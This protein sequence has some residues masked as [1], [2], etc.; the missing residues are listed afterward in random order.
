MFNILQNP[1]RRAEALWGYLL[2]SPLVI[3]LAIFFYL[4]L[5]KSFFISL[6]DW[7]LLS[8][9]VNVGFD[10]YRQLFAN[11]EFGQA[12]RNTAQFSLLNVPLGLLVSLLLA[13][14]LNAKIRFRNIYRLIFFLPVMTM[15]IAISIVWQWL[16]NPDFG[17]INQLLRVFGV[18]KIKWLSDPNTAMLSLVIM[19]V[20]MGA[21]YGMIIILAGLQ[22][23]PR[24]F[25]EAAQVDGA[26][27]LTSFRYVTLPLLTPTLFFV[28]VTSIISSLQVFDIV[29]GLSQG[30]AGPYT[31]TI[32]YS[33][34]EDG[35]RNFQMGNATAT[36][37]VLFVIILIITMIQF[38]VQ[39]WWVHYE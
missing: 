36:A 37:W 17:P 34:Y 35:F 8:E 1:V 25:Y 12:L 9:P 30:R 10:N 23:I 31:R 26:T 22:N 3:G 21:G 13:L 14:A 18:E 32:V 4:A 11:E 29:Y 5:G 20:W 16:Y 6:T 7:D 38:R 19:S 28:M 24:E 15:P 2:I 33:I 27:G 39:R